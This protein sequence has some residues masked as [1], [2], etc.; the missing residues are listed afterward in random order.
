MKEGKKPEYPE[1]TPGNELQLYLWGSPFWVKFLLVLLL[2]SVA[3]SLGFTILGE[4]FASS[5]SVFPSY[6]SG[7]N[8]LG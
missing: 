3:I 2:C 5:S 7:V 6:I 1:K 4:I 8:Q